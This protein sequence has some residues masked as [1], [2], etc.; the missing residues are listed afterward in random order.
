MDDLIPVTVCDLVRSKGLV[1]LV[2]I[3]VV[4]FIRQR[5][6]H[7]NYDSREPPVIP[8]CIPYIGH[9]IGIFRYGA[10]Y[11]EIAK[12]VLIYYCL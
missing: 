1:V 12:F 4:L 11:F 6:I 9:V 8:H 5:V 2:L 10:K 7:V 3:F